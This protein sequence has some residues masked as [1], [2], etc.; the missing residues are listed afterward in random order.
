[1]LP[2]MSKNNNLALAIPGRVFPIP[3]GDLLPIHCPPVLLS[4]FVVAGLQR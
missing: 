1:L 3:P 4:P 2:K